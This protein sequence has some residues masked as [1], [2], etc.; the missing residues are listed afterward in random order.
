MNLENIVKVESIDGDTENFADM[1]WS[2]AQTTLEQKQNVGMM[3]DFLVKHADM[4]EANEAVF[5]EF[6]DITYHPN[7]AKAASARS[8]AYRIMLARLK[9]LA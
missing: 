5:K 4:E 8:K 1:A 9:G 2:L 7:V 3:Q 6:A